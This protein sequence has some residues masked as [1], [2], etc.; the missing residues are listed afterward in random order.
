MVSNIDHENYY[1]VNAYSFIYPFVSQTTSQNVPV[2]S[3]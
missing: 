1:I 3:T 2:S